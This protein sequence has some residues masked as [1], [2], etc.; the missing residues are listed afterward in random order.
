MS[1][2]EFCDSFLLLNLRGKIFKNAGSNKILVKKA[3]TILPPAI[4]PNSASPTYAV[5][6]KDKNPIH[7]AMLEKTIAR[8]IFFTVFSSA[9]A[10]R[11]PATV[12]SLYLRQN[13]IAKSIPIPI[14]RITKA[15][16]IR[17]NWPTKK[18]A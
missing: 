10:F 14:K 8:P 13:C 6:T 7:A 9:L 11:R 3:I 2:M 15:I 18:V 12:S 1:V 5:G 16:D 17:F 4:I